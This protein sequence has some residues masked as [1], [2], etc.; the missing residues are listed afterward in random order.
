[1]KNL[2]IIGILFI[3]FSCQK[4]NSELDLSEIISEFKINGKF[5]KGKFEFIGNPEINDESFIKVTLENSKL[6]NFNKNKLGKIF[7]KKVYNF[8]NKTKE[9]NYVWISFQSEE[10]RPIL[11]PISLNLD[12][13]ENLIYKSNELQ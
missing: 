4:Q 9:Y 12:V 6:S 5:E 3:S 7:A 10:T 8:S 2:L 1:M 11:E 13:T